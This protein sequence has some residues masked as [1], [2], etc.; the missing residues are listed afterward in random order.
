MAIYNL[1]EDEIVIM[2]DENASDQYNRT[3]TLVLTNKNIRTYEYGILG[4]IKRSNRIPL[5]DL[6]ESNGDPNVLIGK[7]SNGKSRLELYYSSSQQ[8]YTFK[9]LLTEKK[10]AAAI[11]RAYKARAREDAKNALD[12]IVVKRIITPVKDRID[13]AKN[14]MLGLQKEQKTT[15]YKCPFCGAI[16][17]GHKGEEVECDFCESTFIIK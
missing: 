1:D 15:S 14:G 13:A 10:W 17:K 5:S 9:G 4:N 16:V 8:Y 12:P 6:R 7:T 3:V 11:I 2:Q